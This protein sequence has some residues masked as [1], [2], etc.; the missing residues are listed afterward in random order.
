MEESGSKTPLTHSVEE[1]EAQPVPED[2]VV[3]ETQ[4]WPDQVD[5]LDSAKKK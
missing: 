4:E 1:H 3:A 5:L 2:P